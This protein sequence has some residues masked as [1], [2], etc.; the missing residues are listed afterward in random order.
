M[1]GYGAAPIGNPVLA[2]I[3]AK[4]AGI[5]PFKLYPVLWKSNELTAYYS[6][7]T[8]Q[9]VKFTDPGPDLPKISAI[10]MFVVGPYCGGIKDH[11]YIFYVGKTKNLRRRYGDY[12]LE[13]AGKGTNPRDEVVHFLN[14]FDGYTYLHYTPVPEQ[15]LPTAEALLK[16]NL[17]PVANTEIDLEGKLVVPTT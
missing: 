8:W 17:T 16:D 7:R 10:Y 15:E 2:H 4:K 1:A 9:S 14:E 11:S 3:R 6:S 5:Y 13:K 12:L